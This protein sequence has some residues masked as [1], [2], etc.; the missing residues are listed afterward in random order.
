MVRRTYRWYLLK[1][2]DFNL[3]GNKSLLKLAPPNRVKQYL[4]GYNVKNPKLAA[5]VFIPLFT[6]II[7]T[8]PMETSKMREK[9]IK[10]GTYVSGTKSVNMI[11]P[12]IL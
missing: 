1:I 10:T 8:V 7:R 6:K 9:K 4:D 11:N 5:T 12:P 3:P 2:N